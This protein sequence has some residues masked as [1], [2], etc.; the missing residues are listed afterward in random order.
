MQYDLLNKVAVITGGTSGIGLSTAK[1]FLSSGAKVVIVNLPIPITSA[2]YQ[3]WQIYTRLAACTTFRS[4]PRYFI[5]SLCRCIICHWCSV[6][7]GW[8]INRLLILK[9]G[10]HC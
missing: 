8:R 9:I 10:E 4:C 3:I 7:G 1:L 2:L 5:F 6:D